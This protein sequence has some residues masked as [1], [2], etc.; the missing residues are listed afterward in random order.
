MT[1][2]R[3]YFQRLDEHPS[4]NSLHTFKVR[5][6]FDEENNLFGIK[7]M[8]N[9]SYTLKDDGRVFIRTLP[10]SLADG[11]YP[12]SWNNKDKMLIVDLNTPYEK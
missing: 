7:P 3:K 1:F 5:F 11:Y 6:F 4:G 2:T 12:A 10:A 9:G 8:D